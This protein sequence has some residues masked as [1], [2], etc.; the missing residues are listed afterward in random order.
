MTACYLHKDRRRIITDIAFREFLMK[1]V[2]VKGKLLVS[3]TLTCFSSTLRQSSGKLAR[4]NV[5]RDARGNA[6]DKRERE[7]NVINKFKL[8]M[9]EI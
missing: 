2:A 5:R 1:V 3:I 6:R 8:D 9:M 4:E 7:A